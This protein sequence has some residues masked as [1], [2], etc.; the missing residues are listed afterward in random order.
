MWPIF[1]APGVF[2]KATNPLSA[3]I[4]EFVGKKFIDYGLIMASGIVAIFV[5]CLLVIFPNR[6]QITGLLAGSGK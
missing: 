1:G 6:Y 3:M 4:P 2:P 5:P